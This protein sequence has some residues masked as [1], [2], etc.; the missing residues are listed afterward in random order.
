MSVTKTLPGDHTFQL[1]VM[2]SAKIIIPD[3]HIYYVLY[4]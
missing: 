4:K 3:T 1:Q 2:S